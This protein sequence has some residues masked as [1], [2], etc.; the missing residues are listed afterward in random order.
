MRSRT[1]SLG[2][3]FAAG[4][5]VAPM[6]SALTLTGWRAAMGGRRGG[7]ITTDSLLI[8]MAGWPLGS[9]FG[10]LL[11]ARIGPPVGIGTAVS[12]GLAVFLV[13]GVYFAGVAIPPWLWL[14]VAIACAVAA[15]IGAG[16]GRSPQNKASAGSTDRPRPTYLASPPAGQA[17]ATSPHPGNAWDGRL[18]VGAQPGTTTTPGTFL[19]RTQQLWKLRVGWGLMAS[20][21]GSI[22]AGYLVGESLPFDVRSVMWLGGTCAWLIGLVL[23]M[24]GISCPSCRCRV[25]WY[26]ASQLRLRDHNDWL[27]NLQAC[28]R[29][30]FSG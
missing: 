18:P 21:A 1:I 7:G 3:G 15:L 6:C 29:C 20:G 30:G 12:L 9:F 11:A 17:T 14:T 23:L 22:T 27:A 28:P 8:D 4:V 2:L 26:G 13:N 16:L 5:L 25:F 24:V 19:S 10:A